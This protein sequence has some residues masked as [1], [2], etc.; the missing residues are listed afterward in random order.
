MALRFHLD[1]HISPA[2]AIGLRRR[3]IDTETT[4]EAGLR[5]AA[6]VEHLDYA[7]E[8]GRVIFTHDDDYLALAASGRHHAGI[9]YCKQGSRTIG[10]MIEFLQ[11]L[12]L[13]MTP[14][15]MHDHVEFC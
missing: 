6:D 10:Q 1:E 9:V 13:C 5:S 15:D 4:V 3:G 12:H 14:E 11:L 7:L 8:R 2:V